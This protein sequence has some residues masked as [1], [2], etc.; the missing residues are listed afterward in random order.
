MKTLL[1]DEAEEAIHG[2]SLTSTN[3]PIAL[4]NLQELFGRKELIVYKHIQALLSL[5]AVQGGKSLRRME[6]QL[7]KHVRSLKGQG[8]DGDT[9]G[10]IL[11]P[12]VVS[13]LPQDVALEWSRQGRG[14]ENDLQFLLDFL[15]AEIQTRERS[16]IYM[17]PEKTT[18]VAKS[19][20]AKERKKKP[21][22]GAGTATAL[23]STQGKTIVCGLC[24]G[25]H[26]T[27][28]CLL[29]TPSGHR[30]RRVLKANLCFRCL[31]GH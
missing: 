22:S 2:L 4:E 28:T 15:K 20:V 1:R 10:V 17:Y 14:K 7:V 12:L 30:F 19:E 29:K 25:S 27:E 18:V 8:I 6:Q 16:E 13:K 24:K 31:E 11:T 21:L 26:S 5:E 23:Q 3:Y 9:Y